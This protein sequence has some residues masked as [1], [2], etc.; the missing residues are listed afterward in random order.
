MRIKNMLLLV[1][2]VYVIGM[3]LAGIVW[4]ISFSADLGV[5]QGLWNGL[6]TLIKFD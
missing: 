1:L 6:K 5:L 2:F 3:C 4:L